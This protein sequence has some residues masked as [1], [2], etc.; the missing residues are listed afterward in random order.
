MKANNQQKI[1]K[2]V[3]FE[4]TKLTKASVFNQLATLNSKQANLVKASSLGTRARLGHKLASGLQS[5]L[6]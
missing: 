3:L 6:I 4:R 2:Q 5:N 1:M